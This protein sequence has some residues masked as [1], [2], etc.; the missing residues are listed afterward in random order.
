M[1]RAGGRSDV[2]PLLAHLPI[3]SPF[4]TEAVRICHYGSLVSVLTLNRFSKTCNQNIN[5]VSGGTLV[6]FVTY[7]EKRTCVQLTL[8]QRGF[9]LCM[10]TYM[11]IVSDKHSTV[12]ALKYLL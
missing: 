1:L 3:C 2:L 5:T 8:E 11:Q 12:S 4:L 7:V 6:M 9:E 10:S